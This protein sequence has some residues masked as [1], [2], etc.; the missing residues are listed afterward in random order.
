MKKAELL[1]NPPVMITKADARG[2]SVI[3]TG[4]IIK[5]S[6]GKVIETD[7]WKKGKLVFRHFATKKNWWTYC[8]N[9]TEWD[10][11]KLGTLIEPYQGGIGRPDK[12]YPMY[13]DAVIK[14]CGKNKCKIYG[15]ISYAIIRMENEVS[16]DKRLAAR[17][18][19]I[20]R[21]TDRFRSITPNLP[22]GF[23]A[24]CKKV[25]PITGHWA[26]GIQM[27]QKIEGGFME[28]R[29]LVDKRED[30]VIVTEICRGIADIPG[31]FWE[32]KNYAYGYSYSLYGANQKWADKKGD[33]CIYQLKQNNYLFTGNLDTLGY[34]DHQIQ[35]LKKLS[36]L[37][38][39]TGWSFVLR[40]VWNSEDLE[41]ILK[42]GLNKLAVEFIKGQI[43][44]G[45]DRREKHLDRYLGIT[46]Q[47][48]V[49]LKEANGGWRSLCMMKEDENQ[50]LRPAD[51]KIIEKC[52]NS[53]N[54][55]NW[56]LLM[57]KGLPFM[58]IY[59]VI[60]NKGGR[61]PAAVVTMYRDY[62]DLAE[63]RGSDIH[64]EIIYRNKRWKEFHDRY[65][66]EIN[67]MRDAERAAQ[68]LK[69]LEAKKSHFAGIRKDY[70]IN[71]QLF[72]WEKDGYCIEI[73][74]SY[75]DIVIEGQL[76][77]HCVGASDRYMS[78][79]ARRE[80]FIL[81]MRKTDDRKTPYYTIEATTKSVVQYYAAYDRQPDKETVKDWLNRWMQQVRKNAAT[82]KKEGI[83]V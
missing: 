42:A 74:R 16:D 55:Q 77:H 66:E 76:Q 50:K 72:S 36:E 82:M 1:A 69:E 73:P 7:V 39:E 46:P 12:E 6:E 83:A 70:K 5:T 44:A 33:S 24:F 52:V 17:D 26:T 53:W 30:K 47:Q 2:N 9:T 13:R 68:R 3:L 48:L 29:F 19:K 22:K 65:T 20:K 21:I 57:R 61:T 81:F 23:A 62:L 60:K 59:K 38:P 15:T 8:E 78:A 11:C 18:R 41:H 49:Y 64:D 80:S 67:A 71:K 28:R 45:I 79:M 43:P 35:T 75:K 31:G 56:E 34:K 63:Q 37:C 58:H 51:L 27:V 14:F 10:K 32:E 4:K 25:A 54:K 40:S